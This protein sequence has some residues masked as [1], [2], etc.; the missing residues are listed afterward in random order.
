MPSSSTVN[1]TVT[2]A[3]PAAWP[4]ETAN[5]TGTSSAHAPT[6]RMT[7][8]NMADATEASMCRPRGTRT[9]RRAS[10]CPSGDRRKRCTFEKGFGM[11][12]DWH[13]PYPS[14]RMPVFAR[15]VVATSQPLAA[16]AGLRMLL[17]GGNAVDAALAAAITLTVVEPTSNG[18][19]SD[20]FAMVWDG[21]KLSGLNGSGRLPNAWS[22][23]RIAGRSRMAQFGW[24]A[25]TVPGAV[26]LWSTLSRRFGRLPFPELF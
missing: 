7:S 1:V 4:P 6:G 20:A 23:D 15:N 3:A 8:G 26:D 25:V 11:T 12:I 10:A 24:D 13:F 18:I 9:G 21:K 22:A 5:G 14:Q 2:C 19:G 17:R 16:Q